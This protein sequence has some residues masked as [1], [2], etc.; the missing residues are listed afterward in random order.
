MDQPLYVAGVAQSLQTRSSPTERLEESI[1]RVASAALQDAGIT[2]DA[3]DNVVIAASD[4]LDGR[5]IS[6]MLTACPAGA[7]FKDEIKVAD[8]GAF[9]VIAAALRLLTGEFKT[10]LIVSWSRPSECS[11]S[12]AQSVMAEPFFTR[13]FGLSHVT[14]T[15]LLAGCY[16]N[17]YSVPLEVPAEVVAKNRAHGCRNPLLSDPV[18]L[19]AEDVLASR[20]VAFPVRELEMS[21]A[22]DGLT[23]L[24]LTRDQHLGSHNHPTPRLIGMGWAT[25]IYDPGERDL[26]R[27]SALETAAKQAYQMAGVGDPRKDL[28]VAEICDVSA[29]HELMSYEALQFC[30][31]GEASNFFRSGS[32]GMSGELPVNPSGGC[33][34]AYPVFSAGMTRFVECCLQLSGR[35]GPRQI[36]GATTGLAHG[37]TGFA[38]QS[39]CVLIC[40]AA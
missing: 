11:L 13:P 34:S 23:A 33:L 6:S 5:A 8:E 26:T 21:P 9:A 7:Y 17:R 29:W 28:D 18:A 16:R 36:P 35:A 40:Q 1:F 27:F 3:V 31:P 22:A 38:G 30:R 4:A 10:S 20:Y 14:A 19:T 24:V 37:C 12:A 32:T 15:A 39:H 2:R 25:E